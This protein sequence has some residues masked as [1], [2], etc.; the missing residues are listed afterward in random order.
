MSEIID[1][2]NQFLGSKKQQVELQISLPNL[3]QQDEC[4]QI[5]QARSEELE[6]ANKDKNNFDCQESQQ[7]SLM[8]TQNVILQNGSSIQRQKNIKNAIQKYLSQD[9]TE[10]NYLQGSPLQKVLFSNNSPISSSLPFYINDNHLLQLEDSLTE[11]DQTETNRHIRRLK[12]DQDPNNRYSV[13]TY[14][15]NKKKASL[16]K[17]TPFKIMYQQ[18]IFISKLMRA[19]SSFRFRHITLKQFSIIDDFSSYFKYYIYI[20]PKIRSYFKNLFFKFNKIKETV[21]IDRINQFLKG[22]WILKPA[23]FFKGQIIIDRIQIF[24]LTYKN[25]IKDLIVIIMYMISRKFSQMSNFIYLDYIIFVKCIDIPQKVNDLEN[26]FQISQNKMRLIQLIKLELFV[27]LI[28]HILSCLYIIIGFNEDQQGRDNW[29]SHFQLN[30]FSLA[31]LYMQTIYYMIIT[32]TT[33]GYG[34]FFPVTP[35]EKIFISIVALIATNVC[36]FSFSQISEIVKYEQDKKQAYQQMMQGINKEM[37]NVGLNILLQHKVRKYYEFQHSQ[38][39]E[40]RQQNRLTLIENL[41]SQIKQEVLLDVNAEFLKQIQFINQLTVG[42]KEK[43]SLNVKQRIFYPEEVIFREKE[44]NSCLFFI[45]Q[46]S[47]QL[48]IPVKTRHESRD[49]TLSE[50]V[51]EQLKKKDIFG[52]EGF[53]YNCPNPYNAKC[54]TYSVITYIEREEFIGILQQFPQDYEKF[55]F[56]KDEIVLSGKYKLIH[57]KCYSCGDFNHSF[58]D[59]TKINPVFNWKDKYIVK[60]KQTN[61]ERNSKF[62]RK[63]VSMYN[64]VKDQSEISKIALRAIVQYDEESFISDLCSVLIEEEGDFD[65]KEQE[66]DDAVLSESDEKQDQPEKIQEDND[67]FSDD[68]ENEIQERSKNILRKQKSNNRDL[69]FENLNQ[70]NI[71]WFE[72]KKRK[73]MNKKNTRV[74]L[75]DISQLLKQISQ[76]K[77]IKDNLSQ[78][79]EE[80]GTKY[81]NINQKSK[82]SKFRQASGDIL[83]DLNSQDKQMEKQTSN[84]IVF[85]DQKEEF[86]IN[87]LNFE[88]KKQISGNKPNQVNWVDQQ[89]QLVAI[90]EMV[91]EQLENSGTL[92]TQNQT[93]ESKN[94][95]EKQLSLSVSMVQF[96]DQDEEKKGQEN[97]NQNNAEVQ[98]KE[99]VLPQKQESKSGSLNKISKVSGLKGSLIQQ[100]TDKIENNHPQYGLTRQETTKSQKTNIQSTSRKSFNTTSM[101]CNES[102][103]QNIKENIDEDSNTKN[104]NQVKAQECDIYD[105]LYEKRVQKAQKMYLMQE[106]LVKKITDEINQSAEINDIHSEQNIFKQLEKNVSKKIS[107][108]KKSISSNSALEINKLAQPQFPLMIQQIKSI[109]QSSPKQQQQQQQ[110]NRIDSSKNIKQ[111]Q[112]NFE[113]LYSSAMNVEKIIPPIPLLKP[114]MTRENSVQLNRAKSQEE[115]NLK[116][117]QLKR[118]GTVKIKRIEELK[119]T[120]TAQSPKRKQSIASKSSQRGKTMISAARHFERKSILNNNINQL[121]GNSQ[122]SQQNNS[123]DIS[124]VNGDPQ[125]TINADGSQESS[126]Y[127]IRC[128]YNLQNLDLLIIRKRLLLEQQKGQLKDYIFVEDNEIDLDFQ[129]EYSQYYPTQNVKDIIKVLRRNQTKVLKQFYPSIKTGHIKSL[130]QKRAKNAELKSSRQSSKSFF[131]PQHQQSIFLNNLNQNNQNISQNLQNLKMS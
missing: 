61:L 108:K 55:C 9:Y 41:P 29:I 119:E 71:Q 20:N 62:I 12:E 49:E 3:C 105:K 34:D 107:Q 36:A 80:Q 16:M 43:I 35:R 75:S 8:N 31:E 125:Y 98:H 116:F 39:N 14:E 17:I 90:T 32:M 109:N 122:T 52:F 19:S 37:N 93:K 56:L 129:K 50:M 96:E 83:N 130:K 15:E 6:L 123:N 66:N 79:Q 42:C 115:N 117:Q 60:D 23:V 44:Y 40:D 103:F 112:Q 81:R 24:K 124:E 120:D 26:K 101:S 87:N 84:K 128:L 110:Q 7:I 111:F 54:G 118:A 57:E 76:D 72:Q 1:K 126:E 114:Q 106:K 22:K 68:N 92:H 46:G 27:L 10:S 63:T 94:I 74:N 48:N 127:M 91:N 2:Q 69:N 4:K 82:F 30:N 64:A 77:K 99:V 73:H 131:N 104:I 85:S 5:D 121:I 13:D 28:A 33:I 25:F 38:Q 58:R 100:E 65:E 45:S 113:E 88:L 78:Q 86:K 102:Y 53:F 67:K 95:L 18:L 59:C 51:I 70:E 97:L 47:V 21:L 11:E 89:N